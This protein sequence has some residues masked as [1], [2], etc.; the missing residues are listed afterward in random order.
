MVHCVIEYDND[1]IATK[2]V[3]KPKPA[4]YYS[5]GKNMYEAASNEGTVLYIRTV[6]PYLLLS[7]DTFDSFPAGLVWTEIEC[8]VHV[9]LPEWPINQFKQAL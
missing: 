8:T 9:A 1:P 4:Q 6:R 5:T 7:F 3:T 2:T